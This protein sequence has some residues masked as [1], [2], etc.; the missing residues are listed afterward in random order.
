M[1]KPTNT[2]DEALVGFLSAFKGRTVII[3]RRRS[4]RIYW[5]P[6]AIRC[7]SRSLTSVREMKTLN[8]IGSKTGLIEVDGDG[9]R[10]NPPE[11]VHPEKPVHNPHNQP[12]TVPLGADRIELWRLDPQR[13][14]QSHQRINL[15]E[16]DIW[17]WCSMCLRDPESCRSTDMDLSTKE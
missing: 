5:N 4:H 1:S 2:P 6:G 11:K 16:K 3:F 9:Q 10:G 8:Q 12:C 13:N 14:T 17:I 15:I 7:R